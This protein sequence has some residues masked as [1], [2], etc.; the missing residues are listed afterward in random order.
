M[1]FPVSINTAEDS[2]T[3]SPFKTMKKMWIWNKTNTNT[4][5]FIIIVKIGPRI[6]LLPNTESYTK[7]VHIVVK[8]DRFTICISAGWR[9]VWVIYQVQIIQTRYVNHSGFSIILGMT[10]DL[11]INTGLLTICS[12]LLDHGSKPGLHS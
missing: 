8:A 4:H 10:Q 6:S 9:K 11:P 5:I 1:F 3:P 7:Q 2:E 12:V